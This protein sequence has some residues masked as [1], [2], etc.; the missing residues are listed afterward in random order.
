MKKVL[1]CLLFSFM[2]AMFPLSVFEASESEEKY[3]NAWIEFD[4][5]L[6]EMP[7]E[8]Q[9]DYGNDNICLEFYKEITPCVY[10]INFGYSIG[11]N[12]ITDVGD[13]VLGNLVIYKDI[14]YNFK[15]EVISGDICVF[16]NGDVEVGRD[17]FILFGYMICLE[18]GYELRD[19][20]SPI[21]S[22]T[23][24][25]YKVYNDELFDIDIILPTIT[26]IDDLDTYLIVYL[27]ED[28]Y[29][30]N[31]KVVGDYV[32]RYECMDSLGNVGF[33]NIVIKVEERPELFSF[34]KVWYDF[35]C[36][37]FPKEIVNKYTYIF[38][39][40]SILLV[41]AFAFVIIMFVKKILS[42]G[43]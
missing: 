41:F 14:E 21:L 32:L 37:M 33:L 10:Y 20:V 43:R 12:L 40:V 39:A 24:T 23:K 16:Y 5:V 42:F 15:I 11:L 22:S 27:D 35:I 4:N 18:V 34:Y 19:N 13:F 36:F 6:H 31:Y 17:S 26:A 28:V 30:N 38:E 2:F 1:I 3:W 7:K 8:N 29:S 25:A 9:V